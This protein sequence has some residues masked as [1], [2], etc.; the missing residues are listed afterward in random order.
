L[1]KSI[2]VVTVRS[3]NDHRLEQARRTLVCSCARPEPV[4]SQREE[5]ASRDFIKVQSSSRQTA[6]RLSQ[7]GRLEA[8]SRRHER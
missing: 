1:Q 3:A 5:K 7:P 2:G 4:A 6:V 8:F